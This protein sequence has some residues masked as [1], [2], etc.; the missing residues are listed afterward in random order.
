MLIYVNQNFLIKN[1]MSFFKWGW[2]ASKRLYSIG[3]IT[4]NVP[5]PKTFPTIP[6]SVNFEQKKI[7][8][9]KGP[10][11]GT[12]RSPT[13][14]PEAKFACLAET[15]LTTSH[16][17]NLDPTQIQPLQKFQNPMARGPRSLV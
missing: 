12:Q 16:L 1:L 13:H 9:F 5:L 3:P 14:G 15:L 4:K 17:K 8:A 10:Y 11:L 6:Y 2:P 7:S